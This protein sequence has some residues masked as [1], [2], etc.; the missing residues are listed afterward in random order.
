M[1]QEALERIAEGRTIL[2]VAHRF[3]TILSADHILVIDDGK[4]AEEGCHE[5]LLQ[6]SPTYR[7]LFELQYGGV[8]PESGQAS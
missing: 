1:I 8:A 6:R 5:D 2:V 4:I 3:S 7:T